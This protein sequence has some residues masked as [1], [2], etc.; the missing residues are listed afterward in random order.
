MA[1]PCRLR[2]LDAVRGVAVLGI[3]LLNIIDLAMPGYAYVDPRFYGGATGPNWWAWALAYVVADGKMRGMFTM[4]FGASTV[5]IAERARASGQAPALVH[6]ARMATLFVIGMLHAYLIWSGDILVLYA[7]CGA[8]IFAARRWRPPLLLTV[9]IAL[10]AF[11][12][13]NGITAYAQVDA[14]RT[15]ASRP[16]ASS[17]EKVPWQAFQAHAA[18]SPSSIPGELA[19]HR[20]TYA[21]ALA[22]RFRT[23]IF[24]QTVINAQALIDTLGLM[25]I[26]M[27]LYLTGFFSG[28]WTERSYW[29]AAAPIPLVWLCYIPL[30]TWLERTGHSPLTMIATEA[31][32]LTLLRPVLSLGYAAL[33]VLF[34]QSNKGR[35]LADR[36]VATGRMAFS[37][38]L[39]TSILGTLLFNGY[40]LGWY[41]YLER[42]QCF[43][44]VVA[45]WLLMLAWSKP[46]L[47]RFAYGPFEWIWRSLAR[48]HL[49]P[50]RRHSRTANA[51][52]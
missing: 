19:S 7:V 36:L 5:L 25:L 44:V 9:G 4:L 34:I 43:P 41:G 26:G 33:V 21:Q 16:G 46:W 38:Y 12:L 52:Q 51:S 27:A 22:E 15:A 49:Q 35:R 37:N 14:L 31:I 28:V 40:G 10:L 24:M 39:S 18:P 17:S 48:G 13:I 2:P 45:M 32:Q 6:Y 29:I 1:S 42:W 11:K 30:I 8:V 47:E 23:T 3:L 20:G 50:F